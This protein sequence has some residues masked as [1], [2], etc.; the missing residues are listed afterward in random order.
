M[1]VSVTVIVS[2]TVSVVRVAWVTTWISTIN[3]FD[4][5]D[6]LSCDSVEMNNVSIEIIPFMRV[7][8]DR[9]EQTIVG[10]YLP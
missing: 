4:Y 9:G 2:V 7:T 6:W 10:M 5:F 8:N 3:N 1:T